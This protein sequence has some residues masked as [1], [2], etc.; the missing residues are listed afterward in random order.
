MQLKE[1]AYN[2]YYTYQE[3]ESLLFYA[4]ERYPD[5]C[6]LEPLAK[7]NEG[8]TI[9]GVT[10]AANRTQ[11]DT[12]EM[13]PA[14]YVQGGLHSEEGMGVTGAL[15]LLHDML[16]N[17]A[18]RKQLDSVTVYILPCINPDGCNECL[19]KG[20][21][22]RS[23]WGPLPE[24]SPNALIPCDLDG[25]GRILNM[26][27]ED[28]TGRWKAPADCG[29]LLVERL[30][31]DTEGPF[32]HSCMEGILENYDGSDKIT[33]LRRL[34][35]NRMFPCGWRDMANSGDYPGKYT[36]NRAVMDF[37]IDHPNIFAAFDMHNGSRALIIDLPENPD[38]KDAS[39]IR[40]I[41]KMAKDAI[42]LDSVKDGDYNRAAGAK[43]NTLPGTFRSYVHEAFGIVS[44]A[45][46]RLGFCGLQ[47]SGDL[48]RAGWHHGSVHGIQNRGGPREARLHPCCSL[49]QV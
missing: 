36:E 32:Y 28:P 49:G 11:E 23:M 46:L 6:S 37:L 25:D 3:L 38:P 4:R 34:D 17:P 15:A 48:E 7:T 1:F 26:R 42:D 8:H 35:M 9:W 44:G 14:L 33:T 31:G 45:G 2:R 18:Y 41:M 5:I 22:L 39:L 40:K 43:P 10:L 12:P 16:E 19:T 30:P 47:Y 13:R 27:W 24:N 29:G 20:M 21:A